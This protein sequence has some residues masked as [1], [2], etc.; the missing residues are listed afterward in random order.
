MNESS[1]SKYSE[2]GVDIDKGNAFIE[3]IKEIGHLNINIDIEAANAA[4]E[5]NKQPRYD[6]MIQ[7]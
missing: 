6:M 2:A 4:N 5:Q 3:E 7:S 1:K